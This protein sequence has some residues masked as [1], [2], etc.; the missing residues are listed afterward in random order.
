MKTRSQEHDERKQRRNRRIISA[1]IIVLM[2]LS[3]AGYAIYYFTGGTS[4]NYAGH[5]FTQVVDNGGNVQGYSTK[6]DGKV[7]YFSAAPTQLTGIAL[8]P[9]LGDTLRQSSG[10]I[11]LF[12]PNDPMTPV[13]DQ[14]RFDL[15][16]AIPKVQ[17]AAITNKSSLYPFPLASCRNSTATYP[18]IMLT[19]GTRN[20]T[21]SNGCFVLSG[22]QYDYSMVRDK[23]VYAYYGIE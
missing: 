10:I 21:Y 1:A 12:D 7:M 16:T 5:R 17:G 23:L 15:S 14:L 11:F 3:S 9:G 4:I 8:P 19:N 6:L 20:I 22:T 18:F 13:Y 2:V